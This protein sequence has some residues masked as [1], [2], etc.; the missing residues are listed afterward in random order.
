[1]FACSGYKNFVFKDLMVAF[2]LLLHKQLTHHL[3]H[4]SSRNLMNLVSLLLSKAR[5]SYGVL[6]KRQCN[7]NAKRN[8]SMWNPENLA[9]LLICIDLKWKKKSI[10]SNK[11]TN[12][13]F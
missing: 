9:S 5:G 4:L 7:I 2:A 12:T 1:M 6:F 3:N 10:D 8:L 11:V 13:A